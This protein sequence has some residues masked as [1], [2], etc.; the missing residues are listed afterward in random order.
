VGGTTLVCPLHEWTF[1]L[2]SGMALHGECGIRIY[3]C[4]VG[5]DGVVVLDIGDDGEPPPFRTTDYRK[6]SEE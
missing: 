1:D 3:P 5:A 6:Y 2:R 4:H